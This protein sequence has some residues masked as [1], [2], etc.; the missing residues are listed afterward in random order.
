MTRCSIYSNPLGCNMPGDAKKPL[1]RSIRSIYLRPGY[2]T[3]LPSQVAPTLSGLQ[4]MKVL[5]QGWL[6]GACR[7]RGG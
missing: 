1:K 7:F 6:I 3:V 4:R 2:N 5:I